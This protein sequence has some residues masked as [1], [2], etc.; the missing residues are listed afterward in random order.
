MPL[1]ECTKCGQEVSDNVNYCPNC[2]CYIK[3]KIKVDSD[4]LTTFDVTDKEIDIPKSVEENKEKY[5]EDI[6]EALRGNKGLNIE[7]LSHASNKLK[8]FTHESTEE[9]IE[10][11]KQLCNEEICKIPSFHPS[12]YF[13]VNAVIEDPRINTS[14]IIAI[15]NGLLSKQDEYLEKFKLKSEY[16]K[17]KS[18]FSSLNSA[19]RRLIATTLTRP[20]HPHIPMSS[21]TAG[22]IGTIAGGVSGGILAA[23]RAEQ[24][25]EQY[26]VFENNY[27]SGINDINTAR[28]EALNYMYKIEGILNIDKE[29][30]KDWENKKTQIMEL[31]AQKN[32]DV[33]NVKTNGCYIATCVYGSY[34]CPEVWT[35]R[36]FRDDFLYERNIGRLFIK[37]YYA[38]S[39]TIVK[40]FGKNHIFKSFNKCILD[41]MVN[42]LNNAGY[43]DTKYNDKY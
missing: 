42:K 23:N 20:S 27:Y 25:M 15:I 38:I 28:R 14:N 29:T 16:G 37:L 7:E 9:L 6:V 34:D 24:K 18:L 30:R 10:L 5:L 39:P 13:L 31:E 11:M 2:G 8:E 12:K 43:K 19:R 21:S 22:T 3:K 33:Y 1:I 4:S 36:R 26:R 40:R 17:L 35:L 32:N 41:K